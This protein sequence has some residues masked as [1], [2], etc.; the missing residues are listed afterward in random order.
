M[1]E[2]K[3]KSLMAIADGLI[4]SI[5][6]YDRDF[7]MAKEEYH[8]CVLT[9]YRDSAFGILFSLFMLNYIPSG[10]AFKVY[11]YQPFSISES[12]QEPLQLEFLEIPG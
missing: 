8:T 4:Q 2:D 12:R 9:G 6:S 5:K 1:N 7:N 11:A 10:V 3:A